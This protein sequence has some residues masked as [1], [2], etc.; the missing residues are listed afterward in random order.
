MQKNIFGKP[1][2]LCS[3]NP[4]TGFTRNG[5]CS[6]E[7]SDSGNHMVCARVTKEFLEYTKSQGNDLISKTKNF[8]GLKSGDFWC[9]C[10]Y[11]WL[12]SLRAGVA[13]P[14]LLEATN[15]EVLKIIP[16]Q[17]LRQYRL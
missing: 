12:E 3:N 9:L 14:I 1:L 11:R 10:A 7:T 15:M 8:P 2:V 16:V 6:Y 13:P 5:Y 4:L 17:Y